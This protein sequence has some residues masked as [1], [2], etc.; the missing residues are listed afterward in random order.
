MCPRKKICQG[1]GQ[2]KTENSSARFELEVPG[3]NRHNSHKQAGETLAVYSCVKE[4]ESHQDLLISRRYTE[5]WKSK[6]EL[7]A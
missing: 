3:G 6:P 4:Q 7:K 5:P 1:V 2:K